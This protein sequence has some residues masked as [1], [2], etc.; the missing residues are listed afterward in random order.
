[1]AGL[2][3]AA[4]ASAGILAEV[5]AAAAGRYPADLPVAMATYV[6]RALSRQP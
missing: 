3:R 2:R 6:T 1:V 4:R 5:S